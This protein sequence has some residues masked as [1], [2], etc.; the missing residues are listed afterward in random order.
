MVRGSLRVPLFGSYSR[1]HEFGTESTIFDDLLRAADVVFV[2]KLS[3]NDR[4]WSWDTGGT[5]QAGV[6]IPAAERDGGFFPNLSRKLRSPGENEIREVFFETY[7]PQAE[8]TLKS[9]LVHYTSK[10]EET[11]LTRLPKAA[12]KSLTPASF[13]VIAGI[14][15][16]PSKQVFQCMTVDSSTD[17]AVFLTD[18]LALDPDFICGVISPAKEEAARREKQLTFLERVLQAFYKG[19]I[20]EFAREFANIPDPLV[21]AEMARTIYCD[22]HGL[23]N[24]NPFTLSAPG[25]AVREISRGVEW[26]LFKDF[27]LKARS[28][29]LVEM[30]VGRD[31]KN[32]SIDGVIRSIVEGYQEIDALL[33]SA[34]QQ[35]KA[36]AGA[37]F[38]N[39]IERLLIDGMIPFD[40]QAVLAAMRRPDFILPSLKLLGRTDRKLG[41]VLVLSAKTT[42][43]ER[44]KQVQSEIM[45]CNLFLAT[46]D[47]NI[48]G[49]AIEDMA[50]LGI[51][52]VVPEKLK[53]SDVTDY[54]GCKNVIDFKTFFE[55][56]IRDSRSKQWVERGLLAQGWGSYKPLASE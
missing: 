25:D 42:L 26:E 33:L 20:V 23:P 21:L 35:R 8:Q 41:E 18:V 46:V 22:R 5:H 13:L 7:W 6:Y 16:S 51:V 12:F 43:R 38:E 37:S 10:G 29:Q 14:R 4:S 54:Q 31:P 1:S 56:E 2:K 15:N 17:E 49:N 52:L 45:N 40:K 47:E 44:W 27:Q 39:H 32:V 3:R 48:A 19:R 9:R 30:I 50:S 24:L 34:S 55:A 11:H 53:K 36:R 28:L